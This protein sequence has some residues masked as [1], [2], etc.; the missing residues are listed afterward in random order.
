MKVHGNR[1]PEGQDVY[2]RTEKAQGKDAIDKVQK[3][4]KATKGTAKD[5]VMLSGKAK[6]VDQLKKAVE[7]LPDIRTDRVEAI[8]KAIEAGTYRI[9]PEKIVNKMF[10]EI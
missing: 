4:N 6:E 5:N 7:A 10:E 9:E 2:L 1:P 3:A 8:K